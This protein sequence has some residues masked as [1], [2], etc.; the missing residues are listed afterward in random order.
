[1]STI[2]VLSTA[3]GRTFECHVGTADTSLRISNNKLYTQRDG[4]R[5]EADVVDAKCGG[6]VGD[7]HDYLLK[8]KPSGTNFY[9]LP[10]RASSY[11]ILL[12]QPTRCSKFSSLLL[13][14]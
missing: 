8:L 5:D 10:V 1:M 14:I 4:G 3:L 11:C 12:N 6:H 7:D 13:V 2:T 9:G